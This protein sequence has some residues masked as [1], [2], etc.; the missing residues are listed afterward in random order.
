MVFDVLP[1]SH[2]AYI[3]AVNAWKSTSMQIKSTLLASDAFDMPPSEPENNY[4]LM[5]LLL[6]IS[7]KKW[8]GA[9]RDNKKQ[10]K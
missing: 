1:F 5:S 2:Y 10:I 4:K 9:M 7:S 6:L 3:Y 8:T